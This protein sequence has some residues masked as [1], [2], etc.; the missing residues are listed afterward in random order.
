MLFLL[1]FSSFSVDES[2]FLNGDQCFC[3]TDYG[4]C[5]AYCLCDP[6]CTQTQIDSF[7]FTLPQT[8]GDVDI[9][10]DSKGNIRSSSSSTITTFRPMNSTTTQLCYYYN[11]T[12]E[13]SDLITTFLASD[14]NLENFAQ[15]ASNATFPQSIT[16]ELAQPTNSASVFYLSEETVGYNGTLD[17][18]NLTL[19]FFSNLFIPH[20]IG[21]NYVNSMLPFIPNIN[22]V[23]TLAFIDTMTAEREF[24]F[25]LWTNPGSI[26]RVY[27]NFSVVFLFNAPYLELSSILTTAETTFTSQEIPNLPAGLAENFTDSLILVNVANT[28]VVDAELTDGYIIGYPVYLASATAGVRNPLY[29]P[30]DDNNTVLFGVDSDCSFMYN[31]TT[32]ESIA[33]DFN[34]S[35]VSATA[36]P[37]NNQ[38]LEFV[39]IE[40]FSDNA[41]DQVLRVRW[42]FFYQKHGTSNAYDFYIGKIK[43]EVIIPVLPTSTDVPATVETRF[44]RVNEQGT[45][46]YMPPDN[47]MS[48]NLSL[49]FNPFFI[50]R[51]NILNTSGIFFIFGLF[52][53]IWVYYSFNFVTE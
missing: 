4:Q 38:Q 19:S 29:F 22:Y 53:T 17:D 42:S 33:A 23:N 28:T 41:N 1:V 46:L 31:F 18:P 24:S 6:F 36:N 21:S 27:N 25:S 37:N 15:A 3:S 16:L 50:K 43:T 45:G 49:I 14:F 51:E 12:P 52:G 11:K 7:S 30:G 13:A 44:Y 9:A 40:N 8:L 35:N 20:A 5:N 47:V 10:C 2:L 32:N 26:E 48:Y 34:L 39:Y